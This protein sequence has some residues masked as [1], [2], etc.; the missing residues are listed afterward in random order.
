MWVERYLRIKD[1]RS[2]RLEVAPTLWHKRGSFMGEFEWSEAAKEGMELWRKAR[3]FEEMCELN[4]RFMEGDIRFSP[5]WF[6]ES[7]DEESADIAPYL[8]AFNRAGLLTVVSQPG[9][10]EGYYRQR[11]F[12][13]GCALEDTALRI[14]RLSL[15]SELYIWVSR[16]GVGGGCRMP[17][18]VDHFRPYTWSGDSGVREETGLHDAMPG[19]EYFCSDSA[20]RALRQTCFVSVID[21]CWGRTRYLWD[22]LAQELCFTLEPRPS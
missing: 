12:V 21:L 17:V 4:A 2:G 7:L 5:G 6:G 13:D 11:A 22:T 8:A 14:K 16:P 1:A 20:M 10:D 19:H 18:T 3:T 15:C 9:V